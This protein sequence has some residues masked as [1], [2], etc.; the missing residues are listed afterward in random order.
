MRFFAF[1]GLVLAANLALAHKGD[2]ELVDRGAQAKL[3][4]FEL[5]LG[6]VDIERAGRREF[7]F[8]G[9]P[10]AQFSFGLRISAPPGEK[11]AHLP[12]ASVR[13][14]LHDER[15]AVVFDVTED[16]SSWMRSEGTRDWFM[17]LS[18]ADDA[19]LNTYLAARPSATYHLVFETLKANS[20]L[21]KFV[22]RLVAVGGTSLRK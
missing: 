13:L 7:R 11:L 1:L 3:Q 2:G 10:E 15:D 12:R 8:E 4:R 19:R 16:L 22:V 20:T 14:A 21:S 5:D 17:Y 9:L 18:H 6:T